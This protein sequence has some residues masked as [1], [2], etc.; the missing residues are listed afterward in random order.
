M[1][2]FEITPLSPVV[3]AEVTGLDLTEELD[4]QTVS[5]IQDA[6]LQY[7]VLVIRDQELTE[8]DQVRFS[9]QFGPLGR[10]R[11]PTIPTARS[12][13]EKHPAIMLVSN[14]RENG[15]PLGFP[16]DGEMWFHADMCYTEVPHKATMLYAMELPSKGGNTMFASMYEAYNRVPDDLKAKLADKKALH[17]HEYKRTERPSV[18][19][20]MEGVAHYAHPVFIT[21]P[22]TGRKALFVNRLMTAA[23]EGMPVDKSE[24]IL[25]QLF[26]IGEDRSIV[27]EHVWSYGDLVMWD[28]RAVTHA[29]T[30][31]P[32]TDRR[33]LRRT[34]VIGDQPIL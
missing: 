31:F 16:H 2:N 22:E 10:P 15:R 1:M 17:V 18:R 14:I 7:S 5:A 34:T 23:I 11:R 32:D 20:D 30:E 6:W 8:V 13:Q 26:D 19:E 28:N 25:N 27:Y 4:D 33:L 9:E 29:R 24:A 21:H 12:A 3:G